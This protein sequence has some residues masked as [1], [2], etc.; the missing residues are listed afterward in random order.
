MGSKNFSEDGPRF[1]KL[2]R[3]RGK[4]GGKRRKR[5]ISDYRRNKRKG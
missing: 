5:T 3:K 2:K 1:E 4:E